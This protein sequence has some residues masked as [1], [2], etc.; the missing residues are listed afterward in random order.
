MKSYKHFALGMAKQAVTLMRKNFTLGMAKEHK[1]DGSPLTE[2]DLAINRLVIAS[3][4][5]LYP[6]HGVL[7]EEESSL[8]GDEE[9]VWVC[10]PV[11][12][13]IPFSHGVPISTFTL[14]LVQHGTPIL[15]VVA[16]PFQKNYFFAEKGGGAFLNGKPI[17]VSTK[18]TLRTAMVYAENWQQAQ[19][20][21]LPLIDALEK[22]DCHVPIMKSIAYGAVLIA[23]GEAEGVVFPGSQPWDLAATKI[24][25]EEAGGKVTDFHGNDQRYDRTIKG[26]VGSNGLLHAELLRLIGTTILE[27]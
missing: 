23:A 22:Q 14:A 20:P 27:K 12:G 18:N 24:I 7:A 9:F 5:K 8:Q 19:Y 15:G 3:V 1:Q 6:S 10:D 17:G 26:I 13:T 25:I 21:M 11:D 4:R 2:T 16:D